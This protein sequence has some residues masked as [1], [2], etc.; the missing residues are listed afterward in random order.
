MFE[1]RA[2]AVL[3]DSDCCG[4]TSDSVASRGGGVGDQFD[5]G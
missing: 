3:P 5:A 2:F 4:Q 1:A